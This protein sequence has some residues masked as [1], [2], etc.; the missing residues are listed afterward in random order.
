M[1]RVSVWRPFYFCSAVYGKNAFGTAVLSV[2]TGKTGGRISTLESSSYNTSMVEALF[3]YFFLIYS[4]TFKTATS[5]K[6]GMFGAAFKRLAGP[7][8]RGSLTIVRAPI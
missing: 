4:V 6:S 8:S 3:N 2:A 1:K 7:A 5:V